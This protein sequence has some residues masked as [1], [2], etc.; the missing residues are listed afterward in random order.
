MLDGIEK[1]ENAT[2][3]LNIFRLVGALAK[4]CF[5]EERKLEFVNVHGNLSKLPMSK[6]SKGWKSRYFKLDSH[7]LSY[8]GK[9]K[10]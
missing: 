2:G 6:R 3:A 1:S 10:H 8:Y 9:T 7:I 5:E 4:C